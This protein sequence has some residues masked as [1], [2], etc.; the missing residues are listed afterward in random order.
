MKG[1]Y[2][3]DDCLNL[4]ECHESYNCCCPKCDYYGNTI[5]RSYCKDCTIITK[6]QGER[7]SDNALEKIRCWMYRRW[8]KTCYYE[9]TKTPATLSQLCLSQLKHCTEFTFGARV[10]FKNEKGER[11]RIYVDHLIPTIN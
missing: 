10:F 3:C 6:V 8:R 1:Y 9:K 5:M 4:M 7:R 2:Q 11:R